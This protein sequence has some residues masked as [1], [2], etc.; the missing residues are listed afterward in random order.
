[1]IRSRV[2]MTLTEVMVAVI[3]IGILAS[4]AL[5]RYQRAMEATKA[6]EAV[7][8]LE[9][10]RHGEIVY[11][12]DENTYYGPQDDISIITSQLRIFWH[13]REQDWDYSIDSA[14]KDTFTAIATRIGGLYPNGK[15]LI[16]DTA[17]IWT[18]DDYPESLLP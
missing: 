14:D 3:I 10:I 6:K 16:D 13:I 5:P 1:M 11:R 12:G 17:R 8:S 2:G 18:E 15:I 9:Q 7:A 4:I